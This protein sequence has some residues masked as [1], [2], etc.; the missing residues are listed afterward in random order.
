[1]GRITVLLNKF[2]E[3][4]DGEYQ[5]NEFTSLLKSLEPKI[6]KRY[7]LQLFKHAIESGAEAMTME[8]VA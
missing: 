4:G 3:N 1:L 2:D 7:C 8:A 5:F 6:T